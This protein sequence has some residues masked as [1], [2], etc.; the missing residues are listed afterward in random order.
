MFASTALSGRPA[1][2]EKMK[3]EVLPALPAPKKESAEPEGFADILSQ[4]FPIKAVWGCHWGLF[5]SILSWQILPLFSITFNL[6]VLCI[7]LGKEEAGTCFILLER[8]HGSAP[9]S[10]AG[11]PLRKKE[12][13]LF[14]GTTET[15]RKGR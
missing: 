9:A 14:G 10:G 6:E 1:E 8:H 3:L 13:F 5:Q 2:V 7:K 11:C 12:T 4:V 15:D